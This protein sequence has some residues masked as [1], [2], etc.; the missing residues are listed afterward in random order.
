MTK[1][2]LMRYPARRIE[3]KWQKNWR[4]NGTYEVNID[5]RPKYYVLDMFPYPSGAGLHVGH[6]LGYI[7]SDIISRHKRMQGFNVLHP[8]GYDSF[9]LPAEQYAIQRGIHPAKATEENIKQFRS[10]LENIGLSYDWNRELRTSDPDYYQWTQRIFILL[11][12]HYYDI[13]SNKAEPIEKLIKYFESNGSRECPGFGSEI[14]PFSSEDWIKMSDKEQSDMLMNFRLAYRKTSYVNWCEGLGTVLANDEVVNGVSERGGYPVVQKPML[15]WSLRITAYAERLVSDLDKLDWSDALIAQQK[16]WIGRSEGATI[17]FQLDGL[18]DAIA[19]FTTRPDTLFGCSFMVLAPEHD[20]VEELTTTE[21]KSE[22]VAYKN[23]VS[24]R[25]E[26]ERMTDKKV[27]GAFTGGFAKH[28]FTNDLLPVYISEYVLKDYGT[29]AIMAVPAHDERDRAFAEHFDLEVP[30][31][32]DQSHLS[33]AEPQD[34]DGI[35]VNSDFLNGLEVKDAIEKAIEK[36]SSLETGHRTINYKLRDANFSRQ[37]YWGEPFPIIYDENDIPQTVPDEE[38]P[39]RLP[40]MDHIQQKEGK[41]PLSTAE[42]WI[43]VDGKGRREVDTMPGFAGS[44]W[45]FLRYMDPHNKDE[46]FSSEAVQYWK[47]VDCYIGGTEHA[48]GHL[49]Y[50]RFWH[51]FLFDLGR[52][53]TQEPF[54]KLINQGMIQGRSLLLDVQKEGKRRSLHIPIHLADDKDRLSK[55]HFMQLQKEDNR[56]EGIDIQSDLNW[57]S[58]ESGAPFVPLRAEIEKMSKSKYNVV[59][60]DEVIDEFGTDA[61]RMFEMFLGPIEDHKPWDT[62]SITGVVKFLQRIYDLYFNENHEWIVTEGDPGPEELKSLHTCIKKV[63][64]DIERRSFNTCISA[65]M[66]CVNELRDMNCRK[67]KIL[68]PISRLLSP[69][70]PHLSEEIWNHIHPNSTITE[71]PYPQYNEEY[72]VEDQIEYP[73]CING[74]KRGVHTFAKEDSKDTIEQ[75]VRDLEVVKKWAEGKKIVKVIVVPDRMVNL[76]VK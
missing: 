48:V 28:P 4:E 51:K 33:N 73:I 26:L 63:T 37:R 68:D 7:A 19:V 18:D 5:D 12:G 34:K 35:M 70:A 10:Q 23:Y 15:Q 47:D 9:G 6:P 25:S 57:K 67:L 22:V 74:K 50:A 1:K 11:F 41:S 43:K 17:H 14:T 24:G 39:V 30:T 54:K 29:G 2:N 75:T 21:R 46:M 40:H 16:N 27:S 32:V 44:S 61:F 62:Q 31:V 36:L 64:E 72:L 59:N 13:N 52:V 71:Q 58:D 20:L 49:M 66:I 69:F 42:N 76:V 60:P 8:M 56:F 53:P 38:L 45:Y 3:K 65:M 55:K